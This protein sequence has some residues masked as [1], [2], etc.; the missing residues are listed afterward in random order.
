MSDPSQQG[1]LPLDASQQ[2]LHI[3]SIQVEGVRHTNPSVPIAYL[4]IL[5]DCRNSL[6]LNAAFKVAAAHLV[7][8]GLYTDVQFAALPGDNAQSASQDVRI[9]CAVQE[10]Q[11]TNFTFGVDQALDQNTPTATG[12]AQFLNPINGFGEYLRLSASRN[13]KNSVGAYSISLNNLHNT[14]N[15]KIKYHIGY[16]HSK[17]DRD[18]VSGFTQ[19]TD[20]V[21]LG[22]TSYDDVGRFEMEFAKRT[23]TPTEIKPESHIVE[24]TYEPNLKAAL[25]YIRSN[26]ARDHPS[27][28]HR[29]TYYNVSSQLSG[30]VSDATVK[31]DGTY[32]YH[33]PLSSTSTLSMTLRGG[34]QQPLM[35]LFNVAMNKNHA[36]TEF[37]D[38]D[39]EY[40]DIPIYDRY[41]TGSMHT[42][43]L[44]AADYGPKAGRHVFGADAFGSATISASTCIPNGE[45]LPIRPH[46]FLTA[47]QLASISTFLRKRYG[48]VERGL[49]DPFP[50][51]ASAGV[52]V[53]L[54]LSVGRI[55]LN[56]ASQLKSTKLMK[57]RLSFSVSS[58]TDW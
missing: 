21:T 56:F 50:L 8:A 5:N 9:Y 6:Q 3:S 45:D 2:R 22:A 23:A 44:S 11:R 33:K 27:D 30:L 43:G 55:E 40:K 20:K 24:S 34:V 10:R 36:N 54:P 57:P 16:D 18:W 39:N 58:N 4:Q 7:A 53:V 31:F 42:R 14:I 46:V 47:T 41:F 25:R 52:G 19:T 12:I 1:Q 32:Q 51:T 37:F 38:V 29:G 35:N 28:P 48:G 13:A 49:T 15:S 26:D 17:V